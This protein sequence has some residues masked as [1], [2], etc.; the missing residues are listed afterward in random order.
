MDS[1][2]NHSTFF[3]TSRFP[4]KVAIQLNDTHPT[5]AVPELLRIL[6]DQEGMRYCQ[7]ISKLNIILSWDTAVKIARATFAYTNHTVL[8]EALEKWNV[9]LIENVLPRHL[10]II[11]NIN[12]QFLAEVVAKWPNDPSMLGKVIRRLFQHIY[13]VP[14]LYHRG[15]I[16]Q[17]GENG[18]SC[19]HYEPQSQRCCKNPL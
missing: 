6:L 16:S 7:Y 1:V 4:E 11:Y 5:I 9:P 15:I 19:N 2:T 14:A 3:L 10:Q 8:P 18:P 12:S 17:E 13:A